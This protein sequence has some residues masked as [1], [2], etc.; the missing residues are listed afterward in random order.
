MNLRD[1]LKSDLRS[2]LRGKIAEPPPA[3]PKPEVNIPEAEL[4]AAQLGSSWF[5]PTALQ[6]RYLSGNWRG[7][8]YFR[9]RVYREDVVDV[10]SQLA[11]MSETNVSLVQGLNAAAR[12]KERLVT[13]DSASRY[14]RWI[15]FSLGALLFLATL[16]FIALEEFGVAMVFSVLVAALALVAVPALLSRRQLFVYLVMRDRMNRGLTLSETMHSLPRVF[17]AFSCDMVAAAEKSGRLT[18]TLKRLC[19]D[20]LHSISMA[21]VRRGALAYL[22]AVTLVQ[23]L[24]LTFMSIKVL[25]VFSEILMEMG[26]DESKIRTWLFATFGFVSFHLWEIAGIAGAL[27][28]IAFILRF[29]VKY[30]RG[31]RNEGMLGDF[32]G[33]VARPVAVVTAYCPICRGPVAKA[34]LFK[35]A[36]ILE[37]LLGV[38]VPLPDALRSAAQAD[39]NPLY[40]GMMLRMAARVESGET[41]FDALKQSRG[42]LPV[43]ASFKAFARL[44]ETAGTLPETLGR[45]GL[46]YRTETQAFGSVAAESAVP[47]GILALGGVTLLVV[48][49][50]FSMT[51]DIAN[52]LLASI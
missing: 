30:D 9:S 38:G 50:C 21:H 23:A 45:L 31:H 26:G 12:E 19:D 39:L 13:A 17:P 44:S 49:G 10:M 46:L 32:I 28:L 7:P 15:V 29:A 47:L 43:P 3:P 37:N 41:F 40:R 22:G 1:L 6:Y 14:Q 51:V 52:A 18:E 4:T 48:G 11:A 27:V 20:S 33:L 25:P 24:L 34:N 42:H 36:L 5:V 35:A 16:V 2:L 8:A